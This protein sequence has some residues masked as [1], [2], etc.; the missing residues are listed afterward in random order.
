MG[1]T[2]KYTPGLADIEMSMEVLEKR[3]K[4]EKRDEYLKSKGKEEK[5]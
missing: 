5:L 3:R 4:K 1:K 2:K